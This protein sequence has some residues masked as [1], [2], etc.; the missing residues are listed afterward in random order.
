MPVVRRGSKVR[1]EAEV[2][3]L[4]MSINIVWQYGRMTFLFCA[5]ARHKYDFTHEDS[6]VDV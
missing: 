4:P 2:C 1:N 3:T 5:C 6:A